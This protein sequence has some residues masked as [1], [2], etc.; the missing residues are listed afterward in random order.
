MDPTCRLASWRPRIF[1]RRNLCFR[2]GRNLSLPHDCYCLGLLQ[3]SHWSSTSRRSRYRYLLHFLLCLARN[4]GRWSQLGYTRFQWRNCH[5]LSARNN[6]QLFSC[7]RNTPNPPYKWRNREL[8]LAA[9][10]CFVM[11]HMQ[12]VCAQDFSRNFAIFLDFYALVYSFNPFLYFP[13]YRQALSLSCLYLVFV[14]IP[15]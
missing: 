1:G 8:W 10:D 12:F 2:C 3:T 15:S 6:S 7:L 4:R 9:N 11:L 14:P 5:S 13:I